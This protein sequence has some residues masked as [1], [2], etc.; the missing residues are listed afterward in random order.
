[1][2]VIVSVEDAFAVG[3]GG[4]GEPHELLD[5]ARFN[6]YPAIEDDAARD[7]ARLLP[8]LVE[9]FLEVVGRRQRCFEYEC[10]LQ[11]LA[12]VA[13]FSRSF[14]RDSRAASAPFKTF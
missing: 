8:D 3:L 5:A 2:G 4:V 12:F 11:P 13:F 1:M 6:C 14:R 9:V 7:L 10:L